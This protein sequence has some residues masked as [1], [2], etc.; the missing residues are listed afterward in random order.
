MEQQ[1][2]CSD[3]FLLVNQKQANAHENLVERNHIHND[4]VYICNNCHNLIRLTNVP[5]E[6]SILNYHEDADNQDCESA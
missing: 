6:W 2:L 3:C 1:R 4:T 5:H